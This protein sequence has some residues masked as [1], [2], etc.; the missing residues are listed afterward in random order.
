MNGCGVLKVDIAQK[1]PDTLVKSYGTLSES[2][3]SN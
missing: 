2:S 3:A 1:V